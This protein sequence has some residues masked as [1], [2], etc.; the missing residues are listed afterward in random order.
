[1]AGEFLD[2]SRW[3]TWMDSARR[4]SVPWG[5]TFPSQVPDDPWE[6]FAYRTRQSVRPDF[7]RVDDG[8]MQAAASSAMDPFGFPSWLVGQISPEARDA[9]RA[10]YERH[11]TAALVGSV[12]GPAPGVISATNLLGRAI[13]AA[14]KTS[15][16]LLGAL[17]AIIESRDAGERA[18]PGI[19]WPDPPSPPSD[20]DVG[21]NAEH[22]KEE[23]A[24]GERLKQYI[25]DA[26]PVIAGLLIPASMRGRL[27]PAKPLI[28]AEQYA[29]MISSR[30]PSTVQALKGPTSPLEHYLSPNTKSMSPEQ[31]EQNMRL[32]TNY[33]GIP[34]SLRD[35]PTK[36]INE[37]VQNHLRDNLVFLH[38]KMPNVLRDQATNW[39]VGAN[40]IAG[41][42]STAYG[43]PIS[44]SAATIAAHSPQ[45]EWNNNVS[46]AQRTLD[47]VANHRDHIFDPKMREAAEHLLDPRL[48]PD[49]DR[50]GGM[51]FSD[52][53]DPR[54]KA[55]W[56]RLYDHAHNP[57]DY[58]LYSPAGEN[59]GTKLTKDGDPARV[60][61]GNLRTIE[62]AIKGAESKGDPN[63]I[64]TE[65][66]GGP[67][68]VRSM[69]NNV[70]NPGAITGDV[71]ADTHLLAASWGRPLSGRSPQAIHNFG[72]HEPNAIER[73]RNSRDSGIYGTY[74]IYVDSTATGASK[75]G[76]LP[77]QLGAIG[78]DAGRRLFTPEI[79]RST[80]MGREIDA[81]W[82]KFGTGPQANDA[83]QAIFNAVGGFK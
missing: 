80:A 66:L 35:A 50:L 19:A 32:L 38:D 29:G 5:R 71:T 36:E 53:E 12:L 79:K 28:G 51:R 9:W 39:F 81:I 7:G 46:L 76:L 17:G 27:P 52:I 8:S 68:K 78:W 13:T 30:F 34:T 11:P 75:L 37:I 70:L 61:W 67:H 73:V 26:D 69:Y 10:Q 2:P 14:P 15:T 62:N 20:A 6:R 55:V 31:Y 72:W 40:K 48:R 58:H 22:R 45:R 1:M 16:G 63:I 49:V 82:E 47:L 54:L 60:V 43:V 4:D 83:R 42:L 25:A 56:A 74:P 59:M 24:L 77:N 64:A 3:Y 65:V 41:D 18:V 57:R 23:R 21:S 33:P 44:S